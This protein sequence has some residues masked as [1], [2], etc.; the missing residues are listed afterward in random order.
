MEKWKI[1][2]LN[3]S[4]IEINVQMLGVNLINILP[5]APSYECFMSRVSVLKVYFL[6]TG[7]RKAAHKMFV[8]FTMV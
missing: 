6:V 3:D 4:N 1:A 2:K 8:K 5:A 7:K